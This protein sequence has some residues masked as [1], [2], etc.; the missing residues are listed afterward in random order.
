M[1]RIPLKVTIL[2]RTDLNPNL[3]L[4]P[5]SNLKPNRNPGSQKERSPNSSPRKESPRLIEIGFSDTPLRKDS[6]GRRAQNQIINPQTALKFSGSNLPVLPNSTP[7]S[8][9]NSGAHMLSSGGSPLSGSP[10]QTA[11]PTLPTQSPLSTSTQ[12]Q[13][14]TGGSPGHS[15]QAQ[16]Q[17]SGSYPIPIPTR[18]TYSHSPNTSPSPPPTRVN[19]SASPPSPKAE[20][21]V[22]VA[23]PTL[24]LTRFNLARANSD[25]GS[26][27]IPRETAA[28]LLI[29]D[30]PRKHKTSRSSKGTGGVFSEVGRGVERAEQEGTLGLTNSIKKSPSFKTQPNLRIANANNP[31]V[32]TPPTREPSSPL[33]SLPPSIHTSPASI[34][35]APSGSLHTSPSSIHHA[36]PTSLNPGSL[37]PAPTPF[38]LPFP[39]SKPKEDSQN[40]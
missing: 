15:S 22:P 2:I 11:L 39:I 10:S 4:S 12:N 24:T 7:G 16:Q 8:L 23:V 5:N 17:G 37:P 6:K 9:S 27:I 14:S 29:G 19:N 40:T 30:S 31:L 21:V 3:N 18:S 26:S 34:H 38:Q 36:P 33:T 1:E 25:D 20:P 28:G 32:L 35:A 13:Q